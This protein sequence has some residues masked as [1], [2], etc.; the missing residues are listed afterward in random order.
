MIVTLTIILLAL[1]GVIYLT[2][3]L[4]ASFAERRR[5]PLWNIAA[6][7]AIIAATTTAAYFLG[8][9]FWAV[10]AIGLFLVPCGIAYINYR[11][12]HQALRKALEPPR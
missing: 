4:V 2:N 10:V 5:P 6:V 12:A 7:V 9:T 11:N 8:G 1:V 3:K